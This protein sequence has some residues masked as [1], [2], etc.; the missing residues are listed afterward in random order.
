MILIFSYFF[1]FSE[2]S[3]S[4]LQSTSTPIPKN[5]WNCKKEMAR[6][7][8]SVGAPVDVQEAQQQQPGQ[9]QQQ[10]ELQKEQ[11]QQP[12][13]QKEQQQQQ[14]ALQKEQQQQ[15][16]LQKEQ[17]QQP[18]MQQEQQQQPELQQEQ[19]QQP[20]LRPPNDL[21]NT[22]ESL[23]NYLPSLGDNTLITLSDIVLDQEADDEEE[24]VFY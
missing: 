21:K 12:A 24:T 22:D 15:P 13:L 4:I 19:Q 17:Q 8:E 5:N 7:S 14:P 1:F 2:L 9:Q 10:P 11:Q 3:Q 20:E 23:I 16:A 18:A 6:K